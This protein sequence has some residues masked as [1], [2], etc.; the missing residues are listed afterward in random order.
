MWKFYQNGDKK[1]LFAEVGENYPSLFSSMSDE[2]GYQTVLKVNQINLIHFLFVQ[3]SPKVGRKK[4][5]Y[6]KR[7]EATWN[8]LQQSKN[9]KAEKSSKHS[10]TTKCNMFFTVETSN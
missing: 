9:K 2:F 10:S 3:N 8:A 7:K 5:S 4:A 6:I 1:I